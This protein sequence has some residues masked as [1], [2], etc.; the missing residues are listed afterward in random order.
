V[1]T[2]ARLRRLH[3]DALDIL[4]AAPPAPTADETELRV[5]F[6]CYGNSCRSPLAEGILRAKLAAAGLLGRVA[7]DSAGTHAGDVGA[8]PDWRSRRVARRNGVRIGDL[9][10]RLFAAEDFERF[11]RIVVLD[12]ANRADVLALAP[13]DAARSRVRLLRDGG[14]ADPVAGQSEDF[15]RTYR[16][17]DEACERLLA[18]LEA[19]L[20]VR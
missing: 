11:D 7:V 4:T 12:D 8:P 2:R 3:G 6:V 1:I 10:A 19:D 15:E 17:I 20:A 14:V 5:L 16:Q 13:D 18:E 9:R